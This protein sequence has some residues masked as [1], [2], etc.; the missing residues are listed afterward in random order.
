MLRNA[1]G[2][3]TMLTRTLEEFVTRIRQWRG[4]KPSG[5]PP[6]TKPDVYFANR[7]LTLRR[8]LP[9][10]LHYP[11]VVTTRRDQVRLYLS[12]DPIDEKVA[13]NV[14]VAYRTSYFPPVPL[15]LPAR[16]TILDLGAHHGFYAVHALAV[17]PQ[18]NII[19]VEPNRAAIR[20]LKW[21]VRLNHWLPRT[22][23][24][25]AGLAATTTTG[26]LRLSTAG[27]WGD[28]LFEPAETTRA[29][30]RVPL[31]TLADLLQE[32]R[33]EI[34]KCNAEGAEFEF[35][36]QLLAMPWRPALLSIAVHEDWGD[37]QAMVVALQKE[38]YQTMK[39]GEP[40]RPV[41]HFWRA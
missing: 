13:R 24:V 11:V 31:L 29:V 23:I 35:V 4:P 12:R 16:P 25:H 19:C 9:A 2:V 1:K 17:Y 41:F 3:F 21:N 6:V 15:A 34:V 30:Q 37:A 39:T 28:S 36:R 32:A 10:Y 7:L 5:K 22:R 33:P 26:H 38:G 40:H 18:A 27:S 20:L 8:K 14:S